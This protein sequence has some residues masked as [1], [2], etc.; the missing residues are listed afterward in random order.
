MAPAH[1]WTLADVSGLAEWDPDRDPGMYADSTG[2]ALF[3]L[4]TRLKGRARPVTVGSSI[5][6][7]ARVIVAAM[8]SM[9]DWHRSEVRP[10][11]LRRLSMSMHRDQSL[12]MIRCDIPLRV[13]AP[14]IVSC[15]VMPSSS[16]VRQETQVWVPLLPQRGLKV[17][18]ANRAGVIQAVAIKCYEHNVPPFVNDE[19]YRRRLARLGLSLRVDTQ[20]TSWPDFAQVDVV[21][22]IRR[23]DRRLDDDEFSRKPATKLINAW[24]AGSIPIVG[25]ERAYLD[26][27]RPGIDGLVADSCV[28][29][30]AALERLVAERDL[31]E[32]LQ[33][34]VRARSAEFT[35]DGLVAEWERLIWSQHRAPG[36]SKLFACRAEATS[37]AVWDRLRRR[38]A[39]QRAY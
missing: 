3:E 34:G 22:C 24:M 8:P 9:F 5:P 21:L 27:V 36:R 6:K 20:P 25:A 39:I 35:V 28:D 14:R 31:R 7:H 1:F 2:H 37:R 32:R 11:A 33:R 4:Y 17:R 38:P 13:T 29:V 23:R 12:L 26:I 18:D 15:E 16:S 10:G 30:I 19:R